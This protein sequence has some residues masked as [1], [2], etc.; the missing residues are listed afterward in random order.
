MREMMIKNISEWENETNLLEKFCMSN[1][2]LD[3]EE[4]SNFFHLLLMIKILDNE[5]EESWV[6]R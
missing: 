1:I 2:K 6:C 3:K 5:D 4:F